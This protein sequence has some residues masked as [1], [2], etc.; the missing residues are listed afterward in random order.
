MIRLKDVTFRYPD[1]EQD[2]LSHISL[3]ILPGVPVSIM[4]ANGSG[5][6]TLARCLNGLLLP[7]S[8]LVEVEG[9]ESR[10]EADNERIRRLVGMVFQNPDNQIVST[11]VEREIAF[12]MENLSFPYRQMIDTVK[13]LLTE[14][15]LVEYRSRSP[16]YLSGGEKQLL[17][18]AA[19]LAMQPLYL[20]LDEPT[21]LLD[22]YSR[23]K[24]LTTIFQ[25]SNGRFKNVTPVLITQYPEE[26]FFT[27]R[28]I[29]LH[30]GKIEFNDSPGRV[31]TNPER[32]LQIGINVPI[33]YKLNLGRQVEN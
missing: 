28:L 3:K 33:E 5:K 17:A 15:N 6:S 23:K 32:L 10:Q 4:G 8:G 16:H 24:I 25:N 1:G 2:I 18:L 20:I 21:S 19:V 27:E 11:T 31:F 13:D 29:I 14:F 12:G 22:P 26:T 9:F 7:V 30:H